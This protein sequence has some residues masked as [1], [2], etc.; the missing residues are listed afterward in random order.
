M[1]K[2]ILA[3]VFLLSFTG[4]VSS[5]WKTDAVSCNKDKTIMINKELAG[6][7]V[8]DKFDSEVTTAMQNSSAVDAS[9]TMLRLTDCRLL[10]SVN[11]DITVC[12]ADYVLKSTKIKA[13]C[14]LRRAVQGEELG[15]WMLV[16]VFPRGQG[17]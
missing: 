15:E 17:N 2:L 6:Q 16:N 12:K 14:V 7:L 13:W 8:Q 9:V 3:L 4:C 5:H 1:N 10:A 11:M